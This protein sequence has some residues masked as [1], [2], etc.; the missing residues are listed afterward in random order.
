MA[1]APIVYVLHGD[2][3]FA[4]ADFISG[5]EAKLGDPAAASMNITR[6]EGQATSMDALVSITHAMPFLTDRR[7]VILTD[8]LGRMKSPTAKGEI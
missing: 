4:I 8:P 3:E 2:D 5:M 6:L 7:L 1:D